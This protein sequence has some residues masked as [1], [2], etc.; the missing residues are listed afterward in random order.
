MPPR[1]RCRWVHNHRI[2]MREATALHH[3]CRSV[4]N[5]N[6]DDHLCHWQRWKTRLQWQ[7]PLLCGDLKPCN[8]HNVWLCNWQQNAI[9]WMTSTW[10]TSNMFNAATDASQQRNFRQQQRQRNTT[11]M[12]NDDRSV[13]FLA[14][15][16]ITL[17]VPS[18]WQRWS[19]QKS[20]WHNHTV[21]KQPRWWG[22]YRQQQQQQ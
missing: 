10:T 21:Q 14:V 20:P 13:T 6:S 22:N 8:H 1:R 15:V 18:H 16:M 3:L 2:N 11:S 19:L 5:N 4:V 9:A 12:V 7:A 17:N